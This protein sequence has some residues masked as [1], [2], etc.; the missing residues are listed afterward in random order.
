MSGIFSVGDVFEPAAPGTSVPSVAQM[1]VASADRLRHRLRG[2]RLAAAYVAQHTLYV[3][4]LYRVAL[5]TL[6]WRC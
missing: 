2:D 6:V 1:V 4:V 3:F 5:G